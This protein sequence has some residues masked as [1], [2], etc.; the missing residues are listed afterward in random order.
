M[1]IL[2]NGVVAG[3]TESEAVAPAV[4][5]LERSGAVLLDAAC[6]SGP[7]AHEYTWAR[8]PSRD[9]VRELAP[10]ELFHV[11][12]YGSYGG[13]YWD[14]SRTRVVGDEPSA[15]QAILMDAVSGVVEHVCSGVKPGVSAKTLFEAGREW[16]A[17][18]AGLRRLE[19]HGTIAGLTYFGH[20]LGVGWE[21][22]WLNANEE[23]V[24][25]EGDV[26]SVEHFLSRQDIGGVMLEQN[27]IVTRNGFEQLTR[28]PHAWNR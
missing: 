10:G 12:F 5:H 24:I 16:L 9:P 8:L 2:M 1:E 18:H 26:V 27:G 3:A 20:G 7:V 13:Y 28:C 17:D 22:P 6:A 14:F 19:Q 21:G 25:E 23:A 11:D 15:D 4:E